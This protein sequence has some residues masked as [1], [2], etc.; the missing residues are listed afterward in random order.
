MQTATPIAAD[1]SSF[2]LYS[3]YT[4]VPVELVEQCARNFGNFNQVTWSECEGANW[5]DKAKV[6]YE[7]HD[8]YLFDLLYGSRSKAWRRQVYQ[9]YGHWQ[10]MTSAGP[11]VLE[12]GGGLGFTCSLLRD[13]GRRVTYCDVDG[14]AARFAQ[15]YFGRCGQ[16]DIEIVRTPSERLVLREGRQWDLVFSDSVIEH[17]PDP[18][19]TVERL[20]QAVAPGGLLYLIIDAHEVS[21][22]FPMHQHVHLQDLLA[23]A[24]T[25]RSLQHV[26][27]EGDG[28]NAFRRAR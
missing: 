4:G 7:R 11:D 3:E 18:V 21:P 10:W 15:W 27:H 25:L 2:V 5:H 13:E 1:T 22:A 6:Y 14:P 9:Q 8:E 20:A 17:V 19:A 16:N 23:G 26:H 28:L 12:F 24:P